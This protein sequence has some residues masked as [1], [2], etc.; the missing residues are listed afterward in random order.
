MSIVRIAN[1]RIRTMSKMYRSWKMHEKGKMKT[2]FR[3]YRRSRHSIQKMCKKYDKYNSMVKSLPLYKRD[4]GNL[5][6][7][8]N[9]EEDS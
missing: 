5:R 6:N 8:Q 3:E 7:F 9:K 1:K 2:S 4:F